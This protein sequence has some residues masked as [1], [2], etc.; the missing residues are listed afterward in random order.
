MKHLHIPILCNKELK[1]PLDKINI[2]G[3]AIA[4]GHP[5]GCSGSRIINTLVNQL[6][7]EK[8][9]YGIASICNGGGGATTILI[10]N[11]DLNI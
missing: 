10:K 6:I 2:Y 3:G 4:L 11:M 1:I 8:K 9:I 5:L 7:T